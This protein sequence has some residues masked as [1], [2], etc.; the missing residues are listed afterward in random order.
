MHFVRASRDV[1]GDFQSSYVRLEIVSTF[2]ENRV[3]HLWNHVGRSFIGDEALRYPWGVDF[4]TGVVASLGGEE[5][6]NGSLMFIRD[7][8]M[9]DFGKWRGIG[10]VATFQHPCASCHGERSY[11]PL[12]G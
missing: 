4:R 10:E 3:E 5:G 1:Y 12:G 7:G 11:A 6:Q 9:V 2:W 8:R